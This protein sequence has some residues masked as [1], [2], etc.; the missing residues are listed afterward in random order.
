MCVK[1]CVPLCFFIC[2]CVCVCVGTGRHVWDEAG[3][4]RTVV[5]RMCTCLHMYVCVFTV[6]VS[7]YICIDVCV[8]GI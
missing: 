8:H 4:Q 5:I 6:C 3:K 1:V 2:V 7:V